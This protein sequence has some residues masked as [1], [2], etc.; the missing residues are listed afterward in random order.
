MECPRR[1]LGNPLT[2]ANSYGALLTLVLN[3]YGHDALKIARSIF[4]IEINI[5]R[6]RA[7][8]S[9]LDDFIAYTHIQNKLYYDTF[10]DEQKEQVPKE[11]YDQMMQ[12]YNRVLPRFVGRDKKTPR[13]E[14]CRESLYSRAKEAGPDYLELYRTFYRFASS[15]HHM[16]VGG[17]VA[18]T[19]GSMMAHIA[20]S[21][22]HLDDALVASACVIRCIEL[23]DEMAAL[24]LR[25]RIQQGPNSAYVEALKA[26]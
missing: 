22:E 11:R 19:D 12:D 7:H 10:S 17:I 14:W 23:Y 15:L 16:D 9:E 1:F 3:G 13:N 20:P 18:H 2:A 5:L 8:P 4:E 25:N 24:G 21:W 26:L 6:L